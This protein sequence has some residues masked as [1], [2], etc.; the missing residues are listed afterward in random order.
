M[1]LNDKIDIYKNT[2][3]MEAKSAVKFFDDDDPWTLIVEYD[4]GAQVMYDLFAGFYT[5]MKD[6]DNP[7]EDV[8]EDDYKREF[9]KLLRIKLKR[10]FYSQQ[11]FSK[12]VGISE[13]TLSSYMQG[14]SLPNSYTV[15]RMALALKCSPNDLTPDFSKYKK[16][17]DDTDGMVD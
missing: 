8:S 3:P 6:R 10:S 13:H 5:F 7:N 1:T 14:K 16:R 17:K 12:I 15:F 11:E 4:D 2:M 9:R